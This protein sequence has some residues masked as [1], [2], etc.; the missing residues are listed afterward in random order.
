[1]FTIAPAE[2]QRSAAMA[3]RRY[4][5][6]PASAVRRRHVVKRGQAQRPAFTSHHLT[7]ISLAL[8]LTLPERRVSRLPFHYVNRPS[9]PASL[10]GHGEG[11]RKRNVTTRLP[12]RRRY[13]RATPLTVGATSTVHA[14]LP[15]T[16]R[17]FITAQLP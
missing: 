8:R 11:M 1:M 12:E 14:R 10:P 6:P 7:L 17:P 15:A 3:A 16:P 2:C 4:D 13:K 9:S 5:K